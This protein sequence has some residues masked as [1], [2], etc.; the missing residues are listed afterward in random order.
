MKEKFK[1]LWKKIL[2]ASAKGK[3]DKAAKLERKLIKK[4]LKDK[5]K[6]E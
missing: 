1:K 5:E 3:L 4:E 2:K 6:N